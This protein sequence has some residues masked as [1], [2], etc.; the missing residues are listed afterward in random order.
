MFQSKYVSVSDKMF[1]LLNFRGDCWRRKVKQK[2]KGRTEI[3][4]LTVHVEGHIYNLWLF[5]TVVLFFCLYGYLPW[6]AY[7]S[8]HKHNFF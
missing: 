7:K 3:V 4:L 6:E 8:H 2:Q 1:V 5:C